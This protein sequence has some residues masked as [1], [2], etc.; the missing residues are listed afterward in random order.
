MAHDFAFLTDLPMTGAHI[1]LDGAGAAIGSTYRVTEVSG[2]EHRT[3]NKEEDI[4]ET[5]VLQGER[6]W[7]VEEVLNIKL[8]VPTGFNVADMKDGYIVTLALAS[9]HSMK[10]TLDGVWQIDV[11]KIDFSNVGR[12]EVTL[13]LRRNA[14]FT[15]SAQS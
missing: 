1:T 6:K 8:A 2:Y 15:P 13:P 3:R 9:G 5:G 10:S 12:A 7:D 14:G 4:D 11:P